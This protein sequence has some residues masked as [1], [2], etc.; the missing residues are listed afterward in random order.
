MRENGCH[1]IGLDVICTSVGFS[2]YEIPDN[3]L[4]TTKPKAKFF[5]TTYSKYN[6]HPPG[7]II[8]SP[9]FSNRQVS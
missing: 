7:R 9:T 6:L 5:Q 3:L 4:Y 1:Y 2:A 8:Y